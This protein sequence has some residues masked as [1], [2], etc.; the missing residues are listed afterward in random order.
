MGRRM[1]SKEEKL[2]ENPGGVGLA[3]EKNRLGFQEVWAE[4]SNIE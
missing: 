3:R 4:K 2:L 1:K